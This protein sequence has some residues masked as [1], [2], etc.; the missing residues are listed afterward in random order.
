VS[1]FNP[2]SPTHISVQH[3]IPLYIPPSRTS[4]RL[5]KEW[6]GWVT[7][8]THIAASLASTTIFNGRQ[9]A[10]FPNGTSQACMSS[11]DYNLDCDVSFG[12]LYQQNNW[13]DWN[14]TTLTAYVGTSSYIGCPICLSD[15]FHSLC[16][17]N[18][19][20]SF[21]ALKRRV[22]S[23]CADLSFEL[24]S[25]TLNAERI[26]DFYTY[27][28]N[29][30]CLSSGSSWCLL[31][32]KKWFLEFL[33]TTTWPKY[34]DKW[35]PDWSND[36]VNGTSRVDKNGTTILPYNTVPPP[37]ATFESGM[38]QALDY[39]TLPAP[40]TGTLNPNSTIGLEYDEYPLEIQCS[41]CFLQRFKL[42]F[43]SRWG[44]TYDDV[45]GQA[46]DNI[47]KNCNFK[48]TLMVHPALKPEPASADWSWSLPR[49]CEQMVI[50]SSRMNC[51]TFS[52]MYKVSTAALRDLNKDIRYQ[53]MR[54]GTYCLPESCEVAMV[55]LPLP[56][57]TLTDNC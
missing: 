24:G 38:K 28:Y 57:A 26:V 22:R 32:E 12:L 34:T 11:F 52:S 17:E 7:A 16:T 4:M 40:A 13:V 21:N 35:Y 48:Q 39:R 27:K 45:K 33:P 20:T 56:I 36:P 49:A 41:S 43:M 25:A 54:T 47:Q 6:F 55:R 46:W 15:L 14:A 1:I 44:E 18:C 30:T 51:S 29:L 2:G 9:S 50:L 42:G 8:A 3:Y 19:R 23:A 10:I 37:V 31:D 5:V 53:G